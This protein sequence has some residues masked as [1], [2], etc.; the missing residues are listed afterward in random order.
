MNMNDDNIQVSVI[1]PVWNLGSGISRCMESLRNQ[2]LKNIEM[3]IVDDCSTDCD[4]DV[5]RAAAAEDSRIRIITNAE[6]IGPGASRNKGIEA[7]RGEYLAFVDA[8]DYL[9]T[10]FL[11]RLYAKAASGNLDIAKGRIIHERQ[12]GKIS[13]YIELNETIREGLASGE[14]LYVLFTYQHQSAIYRRS[15]LVDKGIRYGLSRMAQDITFLLKVC[16]NANS[17]DFEES[18]EYHYLQREG[19]AVHAFS[20]RTL[21]R[22]LH[23]FREQI[24]YI[25]KHMADEA[26]TSKYVR[27]R[28]EYNLRLCADHRR[29]PECED[30]AK[31]YLE[32]LRE[33]V[34][35]FPQLGK[36]KSESFIVCVLCEDGVGLAN[37]PSLSLWEEPQV[38]SYVETIREWVDFVTEHPDRLDAARNDLYRL[39]REAE[40]LCQKE[41]DT[42]GEDGRRQIRRDL[43]AQAGR[44]PFRCRRRIF[45]Q[46]PCLPHPFV[47]DAIIVLKRMRAKMK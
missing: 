19:S 32:G 11:E 22:S 35:R 12:D 14:P 46:N 23:A 17:F 20:P 41:N 28:V 16:H 15:L 21:E 24:D 43:S 8:D 34:F 33:Q 7:A 26:N 47:Y 31:A 40:A 3:V 25:V 29:W 30:A 2:T 5:V 42:H 27:K 10:T 18:A 6:N 36:L 44:L 39:F 37:Y 13:N 38:E 4:M 9:D 45:E 1:V